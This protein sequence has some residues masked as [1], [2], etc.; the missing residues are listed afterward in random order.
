[1]KEV[2]KLIWKEASLPNCTTR[3]RLIAWYFFGSLLFVCGISEASILVWL[4]AVAN[5]GNAARLIRHIDLPETY[6]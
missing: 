3:Q 5:L 1:M 4:L 2:V 6:D